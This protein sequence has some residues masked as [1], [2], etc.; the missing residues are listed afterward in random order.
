MADHARNKHGGVMSADPLK[1][2]EFSKTGTF[3]KPLN[4]QVD[5]NLRISRAERDKNVKVGRKVWRIILPL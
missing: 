4:R 5:E 3:M 1:D 2:Y